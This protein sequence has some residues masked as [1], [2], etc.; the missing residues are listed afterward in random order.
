MDILNLLIQ[1]GTQQVTQAQGQVQN[2]TNNLNSAQSAAYRFGGAMVDTAKLAVYSYVGLAA[3]VSTVSLALAEHVD[4]LQDAADM[5]GYSASQIAAM[6][7][8]AEDAGGTLEDVMKASNRARKELAQGGEAFKNLGV[9][10]THTN[11]QLK[12]GAELAAEVAKAYA[13]GKTTAAQFKDV[14][15]VLG[16]EM[17]RTTSVLMAQIG[18]L[19]M[20]SEMEAKGIGIYQEATDAT[21]EYMDAKKRA[22]Y[23][24]QSAGSVLVAAVVPA[25]TT[26]IEKLTDSYVNG[27]LVRQAFDGLISVIPGM[28]S[29]GGTVA[30]VFTTAALTA[31]AFGTLVGGVA[32][33]LG[34]L[35][36]GN[37]AG[38]KFIF[39]EM[40]KDID[41]IEALR[42]RTNA[43]IDAT[44]SAMRKQAEAAKSLTIA[45]Q[46][47]GKAS[48]G[49]VPNPKA[50]DKKP[51]RA[52]QTLT[53]ALIQQNVELARLADA[54][55]VVNGARSRAAQTTVEAE[56]A[57]GKYAKQLSQVTKAEGEAM[58]AKLRSNAAKIDEVRYENE[59]LAAKKRTEEVIKAASIA[60]TQEIEENRI[61]ISVLAD[62]SKT[63]DD[64]NKAVA[65]YR[66]RQAEARL[67]DEEKNSQDLIKLN[68]LREEI[69]L[70]KERSTVAAE[71]KKDNDAERERQKQFSEGWKSA[72]DSYLKEASDSSIGA[73]R[74][75]E[76]ASASMETSLMNFVTTGKLSFK[77]FTASVLADIAK[78]IIQ[79]SIAGI[80]GSIFGGGGMFSF[81]AAARGAVY[82]GSGVLMSKNGNVFDGP[83]L[84]G[85][86]GGIGMLGEAG[87]E[88]VMPLKRLSNGRLG[89][90]AEGSSSGG[91]IHVSIGDIIVQGGK[92]PESTGQQ[93]ANKL[94]EQFTRGIVRQELQKAKQTGGLLNPV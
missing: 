14:E 70:L 69:A 50:Q 61:R 42:V 25:F 91:D 94:A 39:N 10:V 38:A 88:A 3:A 28:I 40:V 52:D 93:V 87:P 19:E 47:A 86:A 78:I 92:D 53:K 37:F 15:K 30:K 89:V 23:V 79:K 18:A 35:V 56:I 64:L 59:V 46:Q 24:M 27:G 81:N 6:K 41:G 66:L 84:H 75:F 16:E 22:T 33:S 90:A 29:F 36:Q 13:D 51:E 4:D 17:D 67:A 77:E 58:L 45:K 34:Q 80:A 82:G 20:V 85:Y 71:A 11:G 60:A 8:A 68:Q 9:A 32:A 63:Q 73:R 65:E 1:V 21:N 44:T 26:L 54:T 7:S 76:T 2:L 5:Y 62:H 31:K 83:T 12:S 57:E 72:Y 43:G 55:N 48:T 49:D 74:L